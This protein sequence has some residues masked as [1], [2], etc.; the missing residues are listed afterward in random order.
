MKR[1]TREETT[2]PVVYTFTHYLMVD[3]DGYGK[4]KMYINN[5]LKQECVWSKGLVED[6]L[7]KH[8]WKVI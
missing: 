4:Y 1:Y 7:K 6:E 3:D 8:D 5:E 2:G